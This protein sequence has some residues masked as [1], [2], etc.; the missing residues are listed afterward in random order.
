MAGEFQR[1]VRTLAG[2]YEL[3]RISPWLVSPINRV[4]LQFFS[5]KLLRLVVPYLAIIAFATSVLLA[6]ASSLFLTI[7][8]LQGAV[9]GLTLIG[10]TA[11]IKPISKTTAPFAALIGL[12]AAAVFGLYRFLFAEGPLWKIWVTPE[13]QGKVGTVV[14]IEASRAIYT[15]PSPST[16]ADTNSPSRPV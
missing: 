2:N 3:I 10:V 12:N 7:A 6:R 4:V 14:D 15:H 5:H 13:P 16:V 11:T 8:A 1:K 9:F